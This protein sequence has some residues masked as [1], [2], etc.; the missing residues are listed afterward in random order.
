[1]IRLFVVDQDVSRAN[2]VPLQTQEPLLLV[3]LT[4]ANP[5]IGWLTL[6]STWLLVNFRCILLHNVVKL[7]YFLSMEQM[8]KFSPY[9]SLK[10]TYLPNTM[11]Q[12]FF[13]CGPWCSYIMDTNILLTECINCIH[14]T[15]RKVI[16]CI[17]WQS[18]PTVQK[19]KLLF[20]VFR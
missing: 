13:S 12:L 11:L 2:T 16:N 14:A 3:R 1:M 6:F 9:S 10:Y 5:R 7:I 4:E 17:F 19:H 18:K 15:V 8:E 20:S